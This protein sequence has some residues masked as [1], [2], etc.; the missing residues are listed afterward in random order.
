MFTKRKEPET[1]IDGKPVPD[2]R[3]Y[4]EICEHTSEHFTIPCKSTVVCACYNRETAE[5]IKSLI[6]KAYPEYTYGNCH[7]NINIH[8]VDDPFYLSDDYRD[9]K[10]VREYHTD[11]KTN[12]D[13]SYLST[14][15]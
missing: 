1:L 15:F 4:V 11:K 7:N 14:I 9:V 10:R 5:W 12:M 13:L 3:F 6:M 2:V 8:I